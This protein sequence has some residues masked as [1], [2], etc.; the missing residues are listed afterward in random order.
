MNSEHTSNKQVGRNV[1]ILFAAILALLLSWGLFAI[2]NTENASDPL[3]KE[4]TRN[5]VRMIESLREVKSAE[6]LLEGPSSEA[7]TVTLSM[8]DGEAL[9][10]TLSLAVAEMVSSG[11]NG[12]TP[13]GVSVIDI[14]NPTKT[15][16]EIELKGVA[17]EGAEVL[18]LRR[19]VEFELAGKLKSLFAGM[20]IECVANVNASLD[21]DRVKET[22]KTIDPLGQGEVVL[23]EERT[24]DMRKTESIVSQTTKEILGAVGEYA[25]VRAS[26]VVFDRV[27]QDET[28]AWVYARPENIETNLQKYARLAANTLGV[29]VESIEVQYMKSPFATPPVEKVTKDT[30]PLILGMGITA[31]LLVLLIVWLLLTGRRNT[32]AQAAIDANAA[33]LK[34]ASVPESNEL[35]IATLAAEDVDRSASILKRWIVRGE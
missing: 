7:A 30:R 34:E 28:G 5:L 29:G 33:L 24:G 12:L 20:Q 15:F 22:I 18:R 26:L 3:Q 25:D 14:A 13:E 8:R 32:K 9:T 16:E 6:V 10:H 21:L 19:R 17:K 1:L 4:R 31:T 27:V 2:K 35:D 23:Y 11:V